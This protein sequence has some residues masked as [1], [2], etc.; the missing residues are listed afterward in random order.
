MSVITIILL[1]L[2]VISLAGIIFL[3]ILRKGNGICEIHPVIER[4]KEIGELSFY[5]LYSKEIIIE[6]RDILKG[7]R[8][9][10]LKKFFISKRMIILMIEFTADFKINLRDPN[11]LII[12]DY[13]ASEVTFSLPPIQYSMNVKDIKFVDEKEAKILPFML[14][15]ILS[16][17]VKKSVEERNELIEMGKEKIEKIIAEFLTIHKTEIEEVLKKT[18]KT[19][20]QG[21]NYYNIKIISSEANPILTQFDTSK[22]E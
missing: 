2:L 21:F 13:E 5:R 16:S 7:N 19:L 11:F 6:S 10:F 4:V 15:E 22:I 12:A 18:L 8:F 20:S 9:A 17:Q 1:V 14:P 3:L